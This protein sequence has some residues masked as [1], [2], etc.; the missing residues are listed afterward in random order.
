MP[1]ARRVPIEEA[2]LFATL[3]NGIV[4]RPQ[5]VNDF[6]R[7][8]NLLAPLIAP[9]P[10]EKKCI[11]RHPRRQQVASQFSAGGVGYRREPF[12]VSWTIEITQFFRRNLWHR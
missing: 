11:G 5:I 2:D 7:K 1:L 6:V 10:S 12:R 8:P 4:A 9:H 3:A